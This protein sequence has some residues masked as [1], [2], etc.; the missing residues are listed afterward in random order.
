[1]LGIIAAMQLEMDAISAKIEN[2]K[3]ETISGIQYI[4]G[5]IYGYP[6][7]AAVSGIG[8]VNAAVCAQTMC[9]RYHPQAVINTGVGG[10]L[11][12]DLK[13]A[14]VVVGEAAVQHDVDTSAL[15]DEK[16]F[17]ST[18]NLLRFPLCPSLADRLLASLCFLGIRAR[19]GVIATGD[20]FVAEKSVKEEIS[21]RFGAIACEMEGCAIA[22]VCYL[23]QTPCAIV[24]AISDGADNGAS[25]S[26]QEFAALAAGQS[27][28]A[29]LHYIKTSLA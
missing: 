23:N 7:V 20:Q 24:R 13:V 2:K 27:V 22:H 28:K 14:D 15:G 6:V 8:K 26:Y 11:H 12:A 17:V 5:E 1:M 4:T 9:L 21:S 16:G 19:K 25:M 29:L 18:V 3:T 10:S